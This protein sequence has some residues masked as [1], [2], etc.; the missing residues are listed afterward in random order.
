MA[1]LEGRKKRHLNG[2][3]AAFVDLAA[4][5]DTDEPA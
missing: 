1:E 5:E 2:V 3:M 4:G